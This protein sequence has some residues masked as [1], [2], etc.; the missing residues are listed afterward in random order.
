MKT[1]WMWYHYNLCVIGMHLPQNNNALFYGH[2]SY[3]MTAYYCFTAMRTKELQTRERWDENKKEPVGLGNGVA[4]DKVTAEGQVIMLC[5]Q[6]LVAA[7]WEH[8]A[9]VRGHDV[10]VD[11]T[12][13]WSW[14]WLVPLWYDC[15]SVRCGVW[16]MASGQTHG[17][18]LLSF[19]VVSNYRLMWANER[20][21]R[22]ISQTLNYPSVKLYWAW[23]DRRY[24]VLSQCEFGSQWS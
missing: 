2:L 24:H 13:L 20:N 11:G 10:S 19:L 1:L 14:W 16:E 12:K 4:V 22:G 3:L 7:I 8:G 17:C 21:D 9:L 18:L 23:G 5:C 15:V 6:W